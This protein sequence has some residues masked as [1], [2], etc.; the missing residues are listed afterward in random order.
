MEMGAPDSGM[1]GTEQGAA[2]SLLSSF[3]TI[4]PA[5]RRK[6][7]TVLN[8]WLSIRG[9]REF[10]PLHD[11][12]PLELTDA[13]PCSIL[14]EL[15]SGGHDAEIRHLGDGLKG[16][17]TVDRLID[18]PNPSLLSL[19]SK[20]LPI[21]A[22][23][24]DFLAF[25]DQYSTAAGAS[26]FWVTL[27]PLSACGN[28]VDYVYAFVSFKTPGETK[29]AVVES[30]EPEASAPIETVEEPAA[31]IEDP[32]ET[33]EEPTAEIDVEPALEE[34]RD[35]EEPADEIIEDAIEQADEPAAEAVEQD[36]VE[37][38][39][40]VDE[41]PPLDLAADE[42]IAEDIVGEQLESDDDAPRSVPGFSKLFDKVA[43][44]AGFYGQGVKIEP[45]L[46]AG[47]ELPVE[48]APV[49][50][51]PV[52]AASAEIIEPVEVPTEEQ[53]PEEAS[54][55]D[56][57]VAQDIAD[58]VVAPVEAEAPVE[59]FVHEEPVA[60]DPEPIA[61]VKPVEEEM[62]L[63]ELAAPEIQSS[64]T[65]SVEGSLQNKLSD[66]RAKADEARQAKLRAN[67]ALYEGLSAAY[68]FALDAEDSPEEYLRLVEAQGLKIQL[69]SPMKPVVKLAFD[70]MCDDATVK[71]LEAVLAWA[72]DEELPRGSLA[73]RIEEAGGIAPILNRDAKA[74]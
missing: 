27:L 2:E 47:T 34:Q 50:E 41:L 64:P 40:V 43:G 59:E 51:A 37:E 72:F 24:R 25:E 68:D 1:V 39:T 13:G 65:P 16:E 9:D 44:L 4:D 45:Q 66:V 20:K 49:E 23:S 17:V 8:Y 48:E 3:K 61:E 33:V 52:E 5:E 6:H 35:V 53:L 62:L 71:Q 54:V 26:R 18:S 29:A 31:A 38:L 63:A 21:V 58:E 46:P 69:R 42:T 15:I 28:W 60:S 32:P 70:G 12:D 36:S 55:D 22:L 14:L 67:A 19:I 74:A 7:A 57:A 11:L 10:P 73:G 56:E 30:A